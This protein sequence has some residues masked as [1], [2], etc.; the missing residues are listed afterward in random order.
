MIKD[1]IIQFIK[2]NYHESLTKNEWKNNPDTPCSTTTV[3]RHF[4]TWNNAI[5]SAGLIP[6]KKKLLPLKQCLNCG[7]T[8]KRKYCSRTCA[9][10]YSPRRKKTKTC[11]LCE[12][13]ILSSRKYCEECSN[14]LQNLVGNKT[15]SEIAYGSENQSN[16]Y[17]QIREHAR[18]LHKKKDSICQNCG[19]SLHVEVCHIK[20]IKSFSDDT[21]VHKINA[22]SNIILLCRNCH[23]ELDHGHLIL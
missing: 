23:W 2:N 19:Y 5:S 11:A 10:R 14:K 8:T 4:G 7:A 12:T 18:K 17:S 13:L 6:N 21:R 20:P 3:R 16:C 22:N 9:N 1:V 15:K